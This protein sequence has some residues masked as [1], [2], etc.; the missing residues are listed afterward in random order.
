VFSAGTAKWLTF[1]DGLAMVGIGLLA[2]ILHELSAER[3]VHAIE[4]VETADGK[5]QYV[6][7]NSAYGRRVAVH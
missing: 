7:R 3:V 4:I 5:D 1:A 2:L 6:P